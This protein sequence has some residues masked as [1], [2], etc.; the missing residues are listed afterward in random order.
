[1]HIIHSYAE[2]LDDIMLFTA[3]IKY[4]NP[5]IKTEN[6]IYYNFPI[7]ITI[8]LVLISSK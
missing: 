6:A 7:I 4:V 3:I 2:S 1:M 8:Y 5:T